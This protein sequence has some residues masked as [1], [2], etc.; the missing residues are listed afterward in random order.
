MKRFFPFFFLLTFAATFNSHAQSNTVTKLPVDFVTYFI[1]E[2]NGEGEFSNG[3]KISANVSFKLSLDS[4]WLMYDHT[5]I[6][7]NT[8]K[9]FSMWGVD[10]QSGQFLAY[11][12]DNFQGNRKFV[13]DAWKVG[14]LII[15]TH[16]YFPQRGISF[17]HFIYEKQDEKS[18][19]M[20][21]ETSRDGINWRMIDYLVFVKK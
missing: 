9:A 18:F 16:E 14:K 2:W 15:S 12:F 13:G 4:C 5:D 21:Y 8:Y 3:K 11:C 17:Q 1:G 10:K 7:P 6:L 19:K 20:T